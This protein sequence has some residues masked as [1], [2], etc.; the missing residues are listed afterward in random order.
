VRTQRGLYEMT[1]DVAAEWASAVTGLGHDQP[2]AGVV[3]TAGRKY[4]AR[5]DV[6][7]FPDFSSPDDA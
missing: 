5:T 2:H 1:D 4:V 3:V 6:M 7:Y